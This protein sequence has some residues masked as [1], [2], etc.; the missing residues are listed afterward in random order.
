VKF[1]EL[2]RYGNWTGGGFS[3]GRTS[4]PFRPLT[5]ADKRVEPIEGA[6][7]KPDWLDTLSKPHDIA[8]DDAQ[9]TVLKE[10]LDFTKSARQAIGDYYLKLA[11]A[12]REFLEGAK[13]GMQ[14]LVRYN[15]SRREG[16]LGRLPK[17]PWGRFI[18]SA[19]TL[20]FPDTAS[21]SEGRAQMIRNYKSPYLHEQNDSPELA[22]A[23]LRLRWLSDE[24]DGQVVGRPV[25]AVLNK[26]RSRV[27]E[28]GGNPDM[29]TNG[30]QPAA[31]VDNPEDIKKQFMSFSDPDTTYRMLS[32]EA[33]TWQ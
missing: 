16:D 29:V 17:D 8:F 12:D 25:E 19:A 9:Q 4:P 6:D 5:E 26:L 21:R 33:G 23:K 32:D 31:Y 20:V 28:L 18:F 7:G 13:P 24:V 30:A 2:L 11:K 14:D 27:S 15:H 22:D 3:G 1:Y 10:L